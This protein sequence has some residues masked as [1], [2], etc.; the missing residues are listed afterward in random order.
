MNIV[1]I[2]HLVALIVSAFAAVYSFY[3][4]QKSRKIGAIEVRK[5]SDTIMTRSEIDPFK[6]NLVKFEKLS[7]KQQNRI[8]NIAEEV[9]R[10]FLNN[11]FTE[12]SEV[13]WIAIA[14]EPGKIV[15]SGLSK[16]EPDQKESWEIAKRV[17]APIFIYHRGK[18][19]M[20]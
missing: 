1:F 19:V 10:N 20:N 7:D 5:A 8:F 13:A 9:N 3:L 12:N 17:N 4:L 16:D 2:L 6:L 18:I 11:F 14:K 15:A